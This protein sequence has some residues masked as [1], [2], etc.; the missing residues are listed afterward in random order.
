MSKPRRIVPTATSEVDL[1]AE[2][3]EDVSI[4]SSTE[5][6]EPNSPIVSARPSVEGAEPNFEED[7]EP[8]TIV[9]DKLSSPATYKRI[10]SEVKRRN[11]KQK[12]IRQNILEEKFAQ[13]TAGSAPPALSE[14][15][16]QQKKKQL[17][18][19]AQL[20][21]A[22]KTPEKK[23]STRMPA[24]MLSCLTPKTCHLRED[25]RQ[26]VLS[27]FGLFSEKILDQSLGEPSQDIK[28]FLGAVVRIGMFVFDYEAF[29]ANENGI[30]AREAWRNGETITSFMAHRSAKKELLELDSEL[31]QYMAS[32]RGQERKYQSL[33]R[34]YEKLKRDHSTSE[35]NRTSAEDSKR[36]TEIK[37]ETA[38]N[39]IQDKALVISRMQKD[40]DRAA[41]ELRS[42]LEAQDEQAQAKLDAEKKLAAAQSEL[43]KLEAKNASLD[44][45]VKR[46][47][48]S[49]STLEE[50]IRT[51]TGKLA[52]ETS[53]SEYAKTSE[54]RKFQRELKDLKDEIR[55]LELARE[56]NDD[57]KR[58]IKSEVR[59]LRQKLQDS[60]RKLFRQERDVKEASAKADSLQL[61]LNLR[62]KRIADLEEDKKR[63]AE[64]LLREQ[65]KFEKAL[66]AQERAEQNLLKSNQKSQFYEDRLDE[67]EGADVEIHYKREAAA[68]RK[69]KEA[70]RDKYEE[71]KKAPSLSLADDSA[72]PASPEP[73]PA[74]EPEP[75]ASP[76]PEP[77]AE[78]PEPVASPEPAAAAPAP[79]EP[80]AAPATADEPVDDVEID[81]EEDLDAQIAALE[82][83]Q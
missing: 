71:P 22:T 11:L 82:A 60:E 77:A 58:Q 36:S 13:I 10:E 21:A 63:D 8:I 25:Y 78:E 59:Q 24:L 45:A 47:E 79:A 61:Q 72:E 83:E 49:K 75:V 37:L 54:K 39:E 17:V 43:A 50:E 40:L 48:T 41:F 1:L 34:D 26:N 12:E 28:K 20:N 23:K 81:S 30:R 67:G 80:D 29:P 74:D 9:A 52:E 68:E 38:K 7:P 73:E 6:E 31:K 27:A 14:E 62:D 35:A 66:R 69:E 70:L 3:L 46:Y 4:G 64:A 32:K 15:I 65:R 18:E 76:E 51:L 16:F 44:S 33:E 57:S 53:K 42:A 5:V 2:K 56:A 19:K 55:E